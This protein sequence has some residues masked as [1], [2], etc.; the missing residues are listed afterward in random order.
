MCALHPALL[1]ALS[2]VA[3]SLAAL[4]LAALSLAPRRSVNSEALVARV[5][6]TDKKLL[7]LDGANHQLLQVRRA[8]LGLYLGLY[9]GHY[10]CPVHCLCLDP[11]PRP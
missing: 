4:S 3:F 5:A 9:L 1:A 6:S 10:L 7:L 2:L 11:S 8:L